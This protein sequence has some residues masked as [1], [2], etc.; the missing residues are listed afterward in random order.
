MRG[1]INVLPIKA[2]GV[3]LEKKQILFDIAAMTGATVI[4]EE[5]GLK[6]ENVTL[7]MLGKAS[8]VY[9]DGKVTMIID[10]AGDEADIATRVTNIKKSIEETTSFEQQMYR[11]RLSRL[12]GGVAVIKVGA[13]TEMELKN[14]KYKTEDAVQ[15]TKSA[16]E[17]G[18]VAG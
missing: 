12:V 5:A 18:I 15:A 1:V 14:K 16:I 4:T 13:A 11:E 7:D 6:L 8:K 9:A 3:G 10:G 2:F 17:E